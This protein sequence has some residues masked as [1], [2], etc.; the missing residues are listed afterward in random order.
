MTADG[1]YYIIDAHCHIYP[2]KIA[3]KAVGGTDAFY[4]VTSHHKGTAED[5]LESGGKAGVDHFVV[6]SVATTPKQV[7]SINSFIANEVEN[8]GG[9]LTGLGTLH[10]DSDDID[11]DIENIVSLGL[12]GVKLHPDI[13][14]FK[15][16]DD[17][18]MKMYELCQQNRLPML[19]HTGDYR[20]DFSNPNRLLPILKRFPDLIIVGAHLGGWSV[21]EDAVKE[22]APMSNLYVDC[23]SCFGF[24][25]RVD[26]RKIIEG[27]GTDRVLFATDYP[28][29][30]P[31]TELEKF[32]ELGFSED[33]NRKM[34][35]ENAKKVFSIK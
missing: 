2:E 34:L 17:K 21:W 9:R 25:D 14:Q 31:K 12:H 27:Y 1:K 7:R 28:M 19:I 3:A 13:Q 35:S 11:G 16:D 18:C 15:L 23:S 5:L 4:G 8:G 20:Y 29:W 32:F 26:F 22:L 30:T 24:N 6:Q 10:P 33:E